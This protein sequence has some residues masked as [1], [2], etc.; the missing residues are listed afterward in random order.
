VFLDDRYTTSYCNH[1]LPN[2][3]RENL[4]GSNDADGVLYNHLKAFYTMK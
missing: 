4:R 2:W 1:L 3:I